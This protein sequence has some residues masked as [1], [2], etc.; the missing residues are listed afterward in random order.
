[1]DAREL[2][3]RIL[4]P[5]L[6]EQMRWL[7][8]Q[9]RKDQTGCVTRVRVP[10]GDLFLECDSTHHLP[11]ILQRLPDFGRRLADVVLA[12]K[13]DQFLVIDVGANIG[14]T[15]LLLARFAPGG[16]IL[17]IEGDS[18]FMSDLKKNTSQIAGVTVAQAFLSDRSSQIRGKLLAKNGTGH[19]V[20]DESA[21]LLQIQ[22]LD[23]LL[24]GYPEFSCPQ[25]IKVDTDGY[26]AAILRGA[27]RVLSTAKPVVF[28]EWHPGYFELAGESVFGHAEFLV[29]LGYEHFLIFTNRG[30]LLL[31]MRNPGREIWESLAHFS[32]QRQTVDGMHYDI[33]AFPK[34]WSYAWEAFGKHESQVSIAHEVKSAI[35]IV[36]GMP[37]VAGSLKDCLSLLV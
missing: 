36:F 23:D 2:W 35:S 20:L 8:K 37:A 15:A 6:V 19:I 28:Y 4:P 34:Q 27:Q 24:D 21:D 18:S 10:Y 1:M 25:V 29:D 7:L 16:K 14:D 12:L 5:I 33:A 3:L 13:T 17:C 26:D 9:T 11:H 22:T 31:R 30:D 32:S